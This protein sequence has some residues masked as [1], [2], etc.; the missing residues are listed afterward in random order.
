MWSKLLL[1][2][3]FLSLSATCHAGDTA[4]DTH[5]QAHRWRTLHV[6]MSV[7]EYRAIYKSNWRFLR[8]SLQT[9]ARDTLTSWGLPRAGVDMLGV[10][11]GLAAGRDARL[12]LDDGRRMALE[13][14]DPLDGDR[15]LMLRF[16][17]DW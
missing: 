9:R 3:C 14:D 6:D 12:Y 8:K 4:H 7:E 13:L 15:S 2:T 11:A 10:A 1:S 17:I 5:S 16:G